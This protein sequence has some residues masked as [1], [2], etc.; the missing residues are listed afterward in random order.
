MEHDVLVSG[1]RLTTAEGSQLQGVPQR[2]SHHL[3]F[4]LLSP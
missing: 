1:N 4:Q 3:A 2:G